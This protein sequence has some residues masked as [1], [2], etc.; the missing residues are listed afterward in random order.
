[1]L[2]LVRYGADQLLLFR[3]LIG[4][5]RPLI[6]LH[7]QPANRGIPLLRRNNS[8]IPVPLPDQI[9]YCL[10]TFLLIIQRHMRITAQIL[11]FK[12]RSDRTKYK[13][14]IDLFQLSFRMIIIQPKENNPFQSLFLNQFQCNR[15]FIL[16]IVDMLHQHIKFETL[17]LLI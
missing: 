7:T 5:K 11:I 12:N 8:N 1:M 17:Q 10:I 3:Y 9:L 4:C 16:I 13:R 6:P 14:H 15:H 2:Y